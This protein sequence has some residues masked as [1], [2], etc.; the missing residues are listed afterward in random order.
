[1]NRALQAVAG[2]LRESTEAKSYKSRDPAR[3]SWGV[4]TGYLAP[5]LEQGAPG[6]CAESKKPGCDSGFY[7]GPGHGLCQT[8]LLFSLADQA[9]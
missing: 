8:G 7:G 1:M 6:P 9:V 3:E 4:G 2:W 5:V